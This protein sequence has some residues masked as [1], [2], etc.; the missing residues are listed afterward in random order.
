MAARICASSPEAALREIVNTT[1]DNVDLK[2]WLAQFLASNRD[3][4]LAETT[5]KG[6]IEK[7]PKLYELRFALGTLYAARQQF[8]PALAVYGEVVRLDGKG[9]DA[10]LARNRMA[11]I[12]LARNDR[13]GAERLLDEIL[14][15]ES[16]NSEKKKKISTTDG[17]VSEADYDKQSI[18]SL[19]YSLYRSVGEVR[20]ET[21][22]KYE[23][24][25]NTWGYAWPDAWGPC[26][27]GAADPQ[28]FGKN[29]YSG[30]Y[31][32]DA[33]KEYVRARNGRVHVLEMGCGTGAGA[34]HVS[35]KVLPDCTYEAVDM[36]QAAIHTCKRKFVPA[37]KG[38]LKA[39]H[40]NATR[41][42]IARR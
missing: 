9:A 36:Q 40:A 7:Q 3:P 25:F 15:I 4:D 5:L 17:D 16:E 10:L 20:S 26:P 39:T 42:D 37:L 11:E 18:Y 6:F 24:T 13:A 27:N 32:F 19:L 29:A 35:G 38:R 33:V 34:H 30:L 1:P 23:F 22:E 21:G 8:E 12:V 14:A 2:L 28:R 41:L 31:R